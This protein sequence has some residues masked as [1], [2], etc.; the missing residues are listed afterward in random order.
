MNQT[1]AGHVSSMEAF[2]AVLWIRH[3]F[4]GS[5]SVSEL[6]FGSGMIFLN[7]HIATSKYF[8]PELSFPWKYETC[9]ETFIKGT[10]APD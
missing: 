10:V 1:R 6:I 5:G 8:L 4:F 2:E 7:L 3:F 9:Q